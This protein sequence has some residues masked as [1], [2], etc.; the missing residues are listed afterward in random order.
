MGED[1]CGDADERGGSGKVWWGEEC[2]SCRV[3]GEVERG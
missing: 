2:W 3:V 1:G